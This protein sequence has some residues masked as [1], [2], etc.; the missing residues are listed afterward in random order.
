[1]KGLCFKQKEVELKKQTLLLCFMK[2]ASQ[3]SRGLGEEEEEI[4]VLVEV[5]LLE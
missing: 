3:E 1:M 5:V 4:Q 2:E